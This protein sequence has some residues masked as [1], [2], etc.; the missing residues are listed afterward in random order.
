MVHYDLAFDVNEE[1]ENQQLRRGIGYLYT[2]QKQ[3]GQDRCLDA[4]ETCNLVI[5][6]NPKSSEAFFMRGQVYYGLDHI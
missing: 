3:L 5:E 4:L 6:K 1:V 2:A